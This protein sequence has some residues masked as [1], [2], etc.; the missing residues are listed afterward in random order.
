MNPE[1]QKQIEE[2]M[3][4]EREKQKILETEKGYLNIN[5][6]AQQ[7]EKLSLEGKIIELQ[8]QLKSKETTLQQTKDLSDEEKNKL[9]SEIEV[10]KKNITN[11]NEL[12]VKK[13]NELILSKEKITTLEKQL[14]S[15]IKDVNQLKTEIEQKQTEL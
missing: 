12:I 8:S 1:L 6:Q 2:I 5:L 9:Q 10:I 4:Q 15:N 14:A 13:D 11:Q 3:Q 7:L